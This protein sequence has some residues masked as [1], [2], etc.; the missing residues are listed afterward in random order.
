VKWYE[1]TV[2]VLGISATV[3]WSILAVH[4]DSAWVIERRRHAEQ[5]FAGRQEAGYRVNPLGLV[6]WALATRGR[7]ATIA[8]VHAL[9]T[10]AIAGFLASG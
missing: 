8:A 6:V 9:T 5:A 10:L 3:I 2:V 7:V 4:F 1:M